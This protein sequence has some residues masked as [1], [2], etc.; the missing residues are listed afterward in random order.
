M[1]KETVFHRYTTGK[2]KDIIK[3]IDVLDQG[4]H[5]TNFDQIIDL[6]ERS[7]DEDARLYIEIK[8]IKY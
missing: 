8:V 1:S 6:K 2:K 3:Y 5:I 4:K 7:F